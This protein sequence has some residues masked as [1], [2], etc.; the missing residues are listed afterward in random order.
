MKRFIDEVEASLI[1]PE[2]HTISG[3]SFEHVF[4]SE[5]VERRISLL[6]EIIRVGWAFHN[7]EQLNLTR[8][9]K[10]WNNGLLQEAVELAMMFRQLMSEEV[11]RQNSVFAAHNPLSYRNALVQRNRHRITYLRYVHHY[12]VE[13]DSGITP[14]EA[15]TSR[16][17][18]EEENLKFLQSGRGLCALRAV[19]HT[20]LTPEVHS[21]PTGQV[22]GKAIHLHGAKWR[23]NYDA[24]EM[25]ELEKT[26]NGNLRGYLTETLTRTIAS[27][28]HWRLWYWALHVPSLTD[29]Q[30]D[31]EDRCA[32]YWRDILELEAIDR[33]HKKAKKRSY[34]PTLG[35]LFIW[36]GRQNFVY[37]YE[38]P[39][40]AIDRVHR[41]KGLSE[42]DLILAA[43]WL[44]ACIHLYPSVSKALQWH[45]REGENGWHASWLNDLPTV[46]VEALTASPSR[47]KNLAHLQKTHIRAARQ[48]F[49]Q[50]FKPQSAFPKKRS[51][52]LRKTAT[53]ELDV[54][55]SELL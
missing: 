22:V 43:A 45:Y 52:A 42:W 48:E 38:L 3:H 24:H 25:Y 51:S 13:K 34:S 35:A 37:R 29:P 20:F 10:E 46:V 1:A 26:L 47:F 19:P 14:E 49:R 33:A 31:F 6:A 21:I 54:H 12:D 50:T 55:A 15:I 27:N 8:K 18:W 23:I 44:K 16:Y 53:V 4:Q 30:R 40:Q 41:E 11:S 2:F 9:F 36:Q 17:G 5:R 7:E 28:G 39:V 32:L